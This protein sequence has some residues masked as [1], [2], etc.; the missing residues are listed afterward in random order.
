LPGGRDIGNVTV[1]RNQ[2]SELVSAIH[3]V[4]FALAFLAFNSDGTIH[5]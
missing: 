1:Q 2:S 4:T 3:D 5:Q